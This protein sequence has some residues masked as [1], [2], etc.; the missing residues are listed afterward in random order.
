MQSFFAKGFSSSI[1]TLTFLITLF[2]EAQ[3]VLSR[4]HRWRNENTKRL[5][6]LSKMTQQVIHQAHDSFQCVTHKCSDKVTSPLVLCKKV[7]GV[8]YWPQ[9]PCDAMKMANSIRPSLS[10]AK[11][12][13]TES[14]L[15]LKIL[16][17]WNS[18]SLNLLMSP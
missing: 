9:R 2:L 15:D 16:P 17:V 13:L 18:G 6:S 4:L 7:Q 14:S 8:V 12:G 11:S 3:H 5:N 10:R 1:P